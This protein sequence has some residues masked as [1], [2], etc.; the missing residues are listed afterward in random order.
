MSCI[1]AHGFMD[2]IVNKCVGRHVLRLMMDVCL[3]VCGSGFDVVSHA[4]MA[5]LS[6][7]LPNVSR[8]V[9]PA[10]AKLFTKLLPTTFI[11]TFILPQLIWP[12][13]GVH[14]T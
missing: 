10:D 13:C 1:V 4:C 14:S 9:S 2:M 6:S 8:L 3:Y 12:L 7:S 5:S 11:E